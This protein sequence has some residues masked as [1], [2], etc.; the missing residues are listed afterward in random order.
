MF[1]C[2]IK[3]WFLVWN[4]YVNL[5]CYIVPA[6]VPWPNTRRSI[7]IFTR[8]SFIDAWWRKC[9]H[10]CRGRGLLTTKFWI[11]FESPRLQIRSSRR[12][13]LFRKP[14][15][16]VTLTE[17][18]LVC[19]NICDHSFWKKKWALSPP[20]L[21]EKSQT[22]NLSMSRLKWLHRFQVQLVSVTY[23]INRDFH[24]CLFNSQYTYPVEIL[25][26]CKIGNSGRMIRAWYL[27]T[28]IIPRIV[29]TP[30]FD[31]IKTVDCLQHERWSLSVL[32]VETGS[33]KNKIIHVL[34]YC[35]LSLLYYVTVSLKSCYFFW[36]QHTI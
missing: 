35:M 20:Q 21:E 23:M 3:S 11:L 22:R 33:R 27:F 12:I 24:H 14:R 26:L 6:Y 36:N 28:H 1:P 9:R 4:A 32:G 30:N 25:L 18:R 19:G 8:Q 5:H 34:F 29:H 31:L 13:K 2:P 15:Q 17:K 10:I 16:Y 7:K